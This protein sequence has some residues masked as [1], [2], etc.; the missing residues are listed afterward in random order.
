MI[1]KKIENALNDQINAEF[2]SA[3]L[4]LSMSA[5]LNDISLTGFANWMRA[6]YEE[7]MFHAMKM[8]DY[9]LERGGNVLLNTIKEPKHSWENIIDIFEDVLEHE[10][11]VTASINN[12]VSLAIDE[13]DHATV[14][15]LQWFVD[16]QVEEEASVEELLAQLK[17]V[18]GNGSGLFMLDREAAQRKF[19]KPAE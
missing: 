5:Y 16:E 13:K 8:Y 14:N 17:L 12:L 18:G 2:Y 1:S 7:E 15:F 10:Q 11:E 19:V 4:Y 3:Y 6:Q 9:L